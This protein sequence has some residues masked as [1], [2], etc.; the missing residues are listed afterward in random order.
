MWHPKEPSPRPRASPPALS[1]RAEAGAEH[2]LPATR[3]SALP[4]TC[5]PAGEL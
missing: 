2:H 5:S 3:L 1:L 4:Q